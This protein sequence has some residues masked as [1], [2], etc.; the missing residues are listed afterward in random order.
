MSVSTCCLRLFQQLL[1]TTAGAE[2]TLAGVG[3]HPHAVL[4]DPIHGDQALVHQRGDDLGEQFVPLLAPLRAEVGE[5][6]IVDRNPAAKPLIGEMVLAEA[7]EFPG[8]ADASQGGEHPKRDE[9]PRIGGVAADMT[10]DRLDL[11]E[12]GVEIES[13]DKAPDDACLGI[14]VEPFVERRPAHFDLIAV[15]DAKPGDA[16]DLAGERP[17]RGWERGGRRN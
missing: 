2:R 1:E 13:A 3:P 15:R 8:T 17:A 4:R 14:G 7:F 9:Q 5:R 6:V 11:V 12:P 10:L 16:P